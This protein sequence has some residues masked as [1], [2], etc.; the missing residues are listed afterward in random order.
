MGT[1]HGA[2]GPPVE[3]MHGPGGPSVA[4]V[5]GLGGQVTVR[6]TYGVTGAE[7]RTETRQ[8]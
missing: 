6:T 5:H 2:G 7:K 8:R 3:A 4:A 1:I